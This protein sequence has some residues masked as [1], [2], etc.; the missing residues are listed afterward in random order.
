MTFVYGGV[1]LISG[2]NEVKTKYD[3]MIQIELK[4]IPTVSF[5]T[6]YLMKLENIGNTEKVKFLMPVLEIKTKN[7]LNILQWS[8][9]FW[10]LDTKTPLSKV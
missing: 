7:L 8:Q 1:D 9:V 10:C 4:E 3:A 2:K 5:G 6:C